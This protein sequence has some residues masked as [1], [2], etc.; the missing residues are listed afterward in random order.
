MTP[1][2]RILVVVYLVFMGLVWAVEV[3]HWWAARKAN[4]EWRQGLADAVT[5]Q[6]RRDDI[7]AAAEDRQPTLF[8][9]PIVEVEETRLMPGADGRDDE[10]QVAE[11]LGVTRPP[12]CE[13]ARPSRTTPLDL[14]P[15]TERDLWREA[16]KAGL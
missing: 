13:R 2:D 16:L 10:D 15:K 5:A 8:G 1:T 9:F 6:E 3:L 4:R 14:L 7:V 12:H 11:G